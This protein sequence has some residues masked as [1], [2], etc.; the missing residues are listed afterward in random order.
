MALGRLWTIAWRDLGRNRRR[1]I[2]SMLAVALG[3]GLLIVLNGFIAGMVEDS[4][5]N[6]IRLETGHVQ[7]RSASYEEEKVSLQWKDLLDG[8][9]ASC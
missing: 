1:T 7:L 9:E 2:F 5:Q 4:L 3:L 6:A 8:P